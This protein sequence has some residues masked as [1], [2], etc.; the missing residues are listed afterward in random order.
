MSRA[1]CPEKPSLMLLWTMKSNV[2][3]KHSYITEEKKKEEKRKEKKNLM[4]PT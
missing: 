1:G 4:T 2:F 3:F